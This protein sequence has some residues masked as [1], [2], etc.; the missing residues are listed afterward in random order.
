M[1]RIQVRVRSTGL[2]A[3]RVEV[4]QADRPFLFRTFLE[5]IRSMGLTP[6]EAKH[7]ILVSEGRGARRRFARA[8]QDSRLSRIEPGL[9]TAR[10][11]RVSSLPRPSKN[12]A[13]FRGCAGDG[14]YP[15]EKR[16]LADAIHDRSSLPSPA[17]TSGRSPRGGRIP[18][19]ALRRQL[20]P[21][22]RA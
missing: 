10:A 12:L 19:L 2:G 3:L 9:P 7:P 18:L 22:G 6:H 1:R 8:A 20:R 17:P 21:P 11:G 4:L 14:Q 13:A 15:Q 16:L 5:V